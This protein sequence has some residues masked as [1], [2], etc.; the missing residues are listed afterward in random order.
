LHLLGNL[1]PFSLKVPGRLH[2]IATEFVGREDDDVDAYRPTSQRRAPP[3]DAGPY[4]RIL[5]R[6]D[7]VYPATEG[8]DVLVFVPGMDDIARLCEQAREYA[9]ESKRWVVLPPPCDWH[10]YRKSLWKVCLGPQITVVGARNARAGAA[11][12]LEPGGGGT[13]P[14]LRL[15]AGRGAE[16]E[17]R[18][19]SLAPPYSLKTAYSI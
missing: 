13:G 1:T 6:I 11:A 8:G 5:A 4:I 12:P 3:L 14:R 15:A 18:A 16:A 10:P 9:A 19:V 7:A 2:P 17:Q